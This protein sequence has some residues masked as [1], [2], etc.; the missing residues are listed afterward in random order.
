MPLSGSVTINHRGSDQ[1]ISGSD[2]YQDEH[3]DG[4]HVT[5]SFDTGDYSLE[6]VVEYDKNGALKSRGDFQSENCSIIED[7]IV[8]T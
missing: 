8:I 2:F 6:L 5:Y 1:I 7:N 4:A 3:L